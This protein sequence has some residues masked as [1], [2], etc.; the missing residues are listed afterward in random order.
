[1]KWHSGAM[2]VSAS[3]ATKISSLTC[4]R[5]KFAAAALPEFGLVS[6]NN[7]PSAISLANALRAKFVGVIGG[8]V[9]HHDDF[10]VGIIGSEH[11]FAMS[12]Q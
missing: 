8:A 12:A 9:I 2:T 7:F 11:R 10:D 3:M 1:M 6:T 5:A 4:C